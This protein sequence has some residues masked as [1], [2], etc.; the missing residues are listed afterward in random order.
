MRYTFW[1]L[2]GMTSKGLAIG[3]VVAGY[4]VVCLV[5]VALFSVYVH[6]LAG[7]F[8]AVVLIVTAIY[9]ISEMT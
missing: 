5:I 3:V 4:F 8:V 7:A 1:E 6:P 2:L 9:L